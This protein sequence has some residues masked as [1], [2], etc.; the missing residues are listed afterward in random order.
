MPIAASNNDDT[1]LSICSWCLC[2]SEPDL[3]F[4]PVGS[5]ACVRVCVLLMTLGMVTDVD[6]QRTVSLPFLKEHYQAEQMINPILQTRLLVRQLP[7]LPSLTRSVVTD[8]PSPSYS[9]AP[10]PTPLMTHV[11]QRTQETFFYD[12]HSRAPS[13]P[14]PDLYPVNHVRPCHPAVERKR[15]SEREREGG[16]E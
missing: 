1:S 12:R 5:R 16:R 6:S 11:H 15:A 14:T 10:S 9:P 3:V 13:I 8:P 2:V 4:A 7:P